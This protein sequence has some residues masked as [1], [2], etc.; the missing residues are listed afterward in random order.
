MSDTIYDKEVVLKEYSASVKDLPRRGRVG[1]RHRRP[2]SSSRL[3][4]ASGAPIGGWPNSAWEEA[5]TRAGRKVVRLV[6]KS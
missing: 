6:R 1:L 3:A 5:A 2:A 4:K